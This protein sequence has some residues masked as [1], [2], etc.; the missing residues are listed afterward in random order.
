MLFLAHRID[1]PA[2]RLLRLL[3]L[4]LS[5]HFLKEPLLCQRLAAP[6]FR[7]CGCKGRR[8]FHSCKRSAKLFFRP[9]RGFRR[10]PFWADG[11]L[12]TPSLGWL[13]LPAASYEKIAAPVSSGARRQPVIPESGCKST[14]FFRFCNT[15]TPLLLHSSALTSPSPL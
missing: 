3:F 11:A 7:I 15:Q 8:F 4:N 1:V 13:N 12:A 9:L 14:P 10:K 5:L 6:A 2:R